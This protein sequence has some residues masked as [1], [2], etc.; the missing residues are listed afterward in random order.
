MEKKKTYPLITSS[1]K[2]CPQRNFR[3]YIL[4]GRNRKGMAVCFVLSCGW[5]TIIPQAMC[6]WGSGEN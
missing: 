1:L 2:N 6:I 5:F 4:M 3:K